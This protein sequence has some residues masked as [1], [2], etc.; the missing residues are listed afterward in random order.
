MDCFRVPM[1]T[2]TS[3]G[4]A[5]KVTGSKHLLTKNGKRLLVD[6]GLFQALNNLRELNWESLPPEK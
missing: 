3:L 6:C 5:G 4:A 1:R 2:L